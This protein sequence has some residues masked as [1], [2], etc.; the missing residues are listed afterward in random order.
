MRVS[1]KQ[2]TATFEK[3]VTPCLFAG[4][5]KHRRMQGERR[6]DRTFASA[7]IILAHW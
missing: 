3:H 2:G 6:T 7:S 4:P 1:E 5:Y